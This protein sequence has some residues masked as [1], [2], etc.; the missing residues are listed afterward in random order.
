MRIVLDTKPLIK[1]F[2]GEPGGQHVQ[3]ILRSVES[4]RIQGFVSAITLTELQYLYSRIDQKLAEER[5]EQVRSA[6][7][8]VPIEA[9]VAI[10][11]GRIKSR[12]PVPIADAMIAATAIL[13]NALLI[14]D[15]PDFERAGIKAVSEAAFVRHLE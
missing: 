15:D 13:L 8:V 4:G 9:N 7:Q 1:F 11:A 6:L 2:K 5:V 14:S 12:A 3:R 10:E